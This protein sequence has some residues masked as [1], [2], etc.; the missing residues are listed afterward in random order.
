MTSTGQHAT[1][2]GP[3]Q[4][5]V[6]VD[7]LPN[8][9]DKTQF[10]DGEKSG[11]YDDLS[12]SRSDGNRAEGVQ[13]FNLLPR[14]APPCCH[15]SPHPQLDQPRFRVRV[16]GWWR[17][18]PLSPSPDITDSLAGCSGYTYAELPLKLK[19]KRPILSQNKVQF[20]IYKLQ[21]TNYKLQI[22]NITNYKLQITNYKFYNL[23][24]SK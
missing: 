18:S 9:R 8:L 24:I 22:T 1:K 3:M 13:I 19:L 14:H 16:V 17:G 21:I 23:Q 7:R 20:T 4:N 6:C 12:P 11:S 5:L 2:R 15:N 10:V